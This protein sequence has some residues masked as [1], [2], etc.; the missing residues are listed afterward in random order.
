MQSALLAASRLDITRHV[1]L[2]TRR[3]FHESWKRHY[4]SLNRK[5]LANESSITHDDCCDQSENRSDQGCEHKLDVLHS[6]HQ[7]NS[8]SC[9][10]SR[11]A[12]L[13]TP[14]GTKDF[15]PEEMALR[16]SVMKI[17]VA[18]FKRH[19]AVTIETPVFELKEVLTSKY[20]EDSKLI[21]DLQ[22]Q[23]G[24]LCSLR[25]DLTVP[26]ARFL[27]MNKQLSQMKR[28]HI[29]K[30]YRRDQP[31][32][33][34]GRLRE[35]YQCDFDIAGANLCPLLPDAEVFKVIAEI[36]TELDI[37][38]FVIRC[39]SRLLLEGLLAHC[40][41]PDEL[42]RTA[43]STLDK[44]DKM[45]W[46]AVRSELIN[47]K[48]VSV[49]SAD[50]LAE[51]VKFRGGLDVV[52][53]LQQS[54]LAQTNAKVATA[55]EEVRVLFGFL[56]EMQVDH[57]VQF[58]MSLIRGLDYYTGIILEANSTQD[59]L[60]VECGSL[61][62]GGRYDN[63]VGMFMDNGAQIPCVGASIGIERV[64][65]ILEAKQERLRASGQSQ[66]VIRTS[67]VQVY[68]AACGGN[69]MAERLAM[70]NS[71]WKLNVSAEMSQKAGKL[72]PLDQF[73][74]CEKAGIPWIVILGP[75]EIE[76]GTA[77]L[78]RMSDRSERVVPLDQVASIAANLAAC[79]NE[80]EV[81]CIWQ[82]E[83]LQI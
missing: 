47:E 63:L 18:V 15:G 39:N 37:G 77:K 45:S 12:I 43:C 19:G 6:N 24:E 73:N 33:S 58:D 79:T 40:Q 21:Y 9:L 7:G 70:V 28:Y 2:T 51:Y 5:E 36:L 38:S 23:G 76:A 61:A 75:G 13:K 54:S 62:G 42:F 46:E 8:S 4:N 57:L 50:M 71:L 81:E 26:F 83:S 27:A 10:Q 68:V 22:D 74:H 48:Q 82:M 20:G 59:D 64:F 52:E 17:I 30:S 67:P 69:L 14:K 49:A 3:L 65:A 35:F 60:G 1:V 11:M 16:E 80:E 34:K 72:R 32:M 78:R 29:A 55:L 66:G 31:V 56:K 41:V 44:L 25:Y 53:Q